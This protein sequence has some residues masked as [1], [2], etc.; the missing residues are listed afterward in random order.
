MGLLGKD[1]IL[2]T[3]KFKSSLGIE[4]RPVINLTFWLAGR[5]IN[6]PASVAKRMAL[7]YPVIVGRKNLKGFLVEPVVKP[8]EL[9]R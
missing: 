9:P 2:W 7:K 8:S 5:K 3:K 1:N 6:T 4:E